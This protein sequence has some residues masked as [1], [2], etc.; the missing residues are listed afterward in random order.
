MRPQLY[1][2][3]HYIDIMQRHSIC[4]CHRYKQLGLTIQWCKVHFNPPTHH[5]T[6]T[7][8]THGRHNTSS[9]HF[10]TEAKQIAMASTDPAVL[11]VGGLPNGTKRLLIVSN[12]FVYLLFVPFGRPP[13]V[14]TGC[15]CGHMVLKIS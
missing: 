8:T 9:M 5:V 12:F 1:S 11:T 7:C 13:T 10:R 4:L 14:N 6:H 2:K 3:P 15:I